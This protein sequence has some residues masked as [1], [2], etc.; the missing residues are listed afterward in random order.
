MADERTEPTKLAEPGRKPTWPGDDDN[1]SDET[2]L[3][4]P[5][6]VDPDNVPPA[7]YEAWTNYMVKGFQQNEE[8]F[9]RTLAAYMRPYYLTTWMYVGLFIVGV[10]LFVTAAI[11]GLTKGEPVVAIV[12]AGLG[13]GTF[14]AFFIRQPLQALERNLEFI[15]WLGV[16]FNTYWTRLMY[17]MDSKTIQQDLKSAED[18]Y[19]RAIQ[20]IITWHAKL[21]DKGQIAVQDASAG[22][23]VDS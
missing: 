10:S 3:P 19:T 4:V 14:L 12:F 7:L 9:Q 18:D 5:L 17:M 22:H 15:T 20:R 16:S 1:S 8:M 13:A 11:V 23:K 6:P 2:M 21:Q